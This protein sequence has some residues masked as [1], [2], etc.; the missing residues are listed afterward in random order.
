[1]TTQTKRRTVVVLSTRLVGTNFGC[2]GVIR[3]QRTGRVLAET[4]TKPHGFASAALNAAM[5]LATKRGYDELGLGK[6]PD[7]DVGD[8]PVGGCFQ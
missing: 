6:K 7:E 8:D 2:C 1:M 3:S 5:E 4:D